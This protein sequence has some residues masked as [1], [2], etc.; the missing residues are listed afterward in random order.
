[1]NNPPSCRICGNTLGNRLHYPREMMFGWR[2]TFPYVE[3]HCCGCL[4]IVEVPVDL[5]RFYPAEQY[6]SY[7]PGG[8]KR[9]PAWVLAGRRARTR[10]RLGQF[11]AMGF[12]A[13]FFSRQRS[14]HFE[15]FRRARLDLDSRIVDIGCGAG[16]L[17]QQL[18]R[19]GFTRLTG[20]DPFVPED[21]DHGGGLHILKRQLADVDQRFDF[22]MLHHSFEHM[23][24]PAG[25]LAQLKRMLD[26][27]GVL[28]VRIP[29]ADS[30]ARR[31]YGIHWVNWDAPRHIYL[32]TVTSMQILAAAAGFEITEIV[33]DSSLAQFAS[34]DL[35]AR[36][37]PFTEHRRY[38]PG[39]GPGAFSIAEWRLF[40]VLTE[41]LN[42]RRDGD[43]AC[44]YLR[45][46]T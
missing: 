16:K 45:H 18:Q 22:I 21:I 7:R 12:I 20:I 37:I 32:H 40:D 44:F 23:P 14:E 42:N 30:H 2:E 4:Q 36:D 35:Y 13:D 39:N 10:Q 3:C 29:L 27:G 9:Y 1:M 31:K 6:Y 43:S 17:L 38:Q 28:L 11:S 8:A 25:T 5:G 41:E 33:Y 46:R 15:W 19:D 26:E 34:S 24:D